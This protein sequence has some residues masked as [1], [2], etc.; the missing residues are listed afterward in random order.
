M[1]MVHGV[2]GATTFGA[3]KN[4]WSPADAGSRVRPLADRAGAARALPRLPDHRQQHRL[5]QRRSVHRPGDRRRSLPIGG[6]LPDA[7]APAPDAGV[8]R[9]TP[10]RRSIRSTRKAA[11]QDT[12][13]PSMQLCI[14]SIDQSGGCFYGYSC[15]YTDSISWAI[16]ER[17]AADDSRSAR[18]V[19]HAVRRRRDAGS[20]RAAAEEGQEP[21][22]LG[23][24]VGGRAESRRRRR[25][26]RPARRLPRQR[27]RDRAAHPEGRGAQ[28]ERRGARAA[29][30]ADRRARLVRRPRAADV[31]PAGAGVR[32]GH[33]PR[34]RAQAEP[35]RLEPRVHRGRRD[36]RLPHRVASQ[37]ARGSDH[38]LREDQ[39]VP[40]RA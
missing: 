10:A 38:R 19:R 1:E 25:R 11:G 27:A 34:V 21:A 22:R 24:G 9:A 14:E 39:P 20:A 3:K 17:A 18:G 16:A 5:P 28:R 40:R 15:A 31:R 36:H 35:R 30:G 26:S 32:G 4:M 7:V 29:D 33:H 6:G 23:D 13:I 37:R 2:A 8:G 12:P